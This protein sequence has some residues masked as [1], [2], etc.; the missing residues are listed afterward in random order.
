MDADASWRRGPAGGSSDRHPPQERR[1][2]AGATR[3]RVRRASHPCSYARIVFVSRDG[4]ASVLHFLRAE[5]QSTGNYQRRKRM[6]KISVRAANGKYDVLCGRGVLRELPRV[7][8]R[9]Q[10]DGAV[11]VVSS[12]RVWRHWG[13]RVERLL[14]SG[15]RATIL[16]DDAETAKNLSTVE[17]ACRDLVRAGADRRGLVVAVGGGV[18]G[19]VAG[20]VAASYARGIALIHIPTTVVAQVDSAIGG[21]TGVNLPEG[22]NLVGA[23]YPPKGVLADPG[24]LSSL[25]P[26]DFRSGIYEIIKYGVIGDAKLFG[27]LE[28]KLEKVLRRERPA[29]AFVIERSIAQKARVV[30]EDEH[31]SGLREILNFGHTFAHALES[32]TRYRTYLHGEAVGWGMIAASRLAVEKGMLSPREEE[33]I[34]NVIRRVGPLPGWPSIPEAHLIA[35]MQA[36]KKTRAGRLRFVLPERIGAVVCGVE[37]EQEMLVRV[38]REC[39]IAAVANEAR[40]SR[41]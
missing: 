41:R 40:G 7:V 11:F 12:P 29:L 27:F 3:S 39:A 23:F 20:F 32:A 9:V 30:S 37:A 19:D 31:E 2:D 21:K 25:P 18:V 13:T 6:K 33:R 36:D 22:K 38:L 17:R 10:P 26:R 14:G 1:R 16:I 34:A 4:R 35:A 15:R 8:S 28:T 5:N 24:V